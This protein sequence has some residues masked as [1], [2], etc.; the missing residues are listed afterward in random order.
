M[1]SPNPH[2]ETDLY[3]D[4]IVIGSSV[5]AMVAAFKYG[6]PIFGNATHKPLPYYY[7]PHPID[8]SP[9]QVSNEKEKFTYLSKKVE[10]RGIQRIKLWNILMHRLSITGLAPMFGSYTLVVDNVEELTNRNRI[11]LIANGRIVN[12]YAKGK[13]IVFDYPKYENGNKIFMVN[14]IIKLHNI[15]EMEENLFISQD[16]D[17]LSTIGYETVFYKRDKKMHSCCV[18]SII[19]EEVINEWKNSASAVRLLTEKTIFWNIDKQIKISIDR[20]EKKPMLHRLCSSIPDIIER[21]ILDE[22]IYE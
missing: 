10:Y 19:S 12:V 18:K 7:L 4:R 11:K 20:R 3:F 9:I 2:R 8:L 6:I 21:D 1:T 5:E 15:Y 22:E 14:D 13:I 16:C 17:F